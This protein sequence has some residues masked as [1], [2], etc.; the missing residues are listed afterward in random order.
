V[1][2]PQLPKNFASAVDL[3]QLGK[4]PVDTSNVAGLEISQENLVNQVLPISAKK[5]VIVIC[6]SPR[7]E[8]S[9]S[10]LEAMGKYN[11]ADTSETGEPSW[12]LGRVN[13]DEQ[14]AVAQALQVQSVPLA[15]AIIQEQ[16]VPL[17]EAVPP[18]DQIRLVLDKVLTLAAERGVGSAPDPTQ[19]PEVPME[20]EEVEAMTA[21]EAGDFQK[22]KSAYEKLLARKPGEA[23][24]KLGLAQTQLLIR[25]EGLNP[26]DVMTR[27]LANPNDLDL[28][29]SAADL[30]I[31][32][33][34][35]KAA[36]DRLIQAV[37]I[38]SGDER[39]RA[40]EHLVTL[41]LLVDPQDPDLLKARQQLASALF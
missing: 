15:I 32:N 27:A 35:N 33:G 2:T 6:W 30:E 41:F 36:F 34:Q 18:V 23:M 29:L 3:S 22:A 9:L 38:N 37:K 21:M 10:L 1:S 19:A 24:A 39:K 7:S 13:V 11:Q 20:P 14:P 12:I 5:V 40:Q 28:A 31:A 25:I 16:L 4:P 17:F 8:Q 26:Q